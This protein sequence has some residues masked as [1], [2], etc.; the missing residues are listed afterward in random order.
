M[1][2]AT[3]KKGRDRCQNTPRPATVW[4]FPK[5]S[6]ASA[7]AMRRGATL[8]RG[9][10]RQ[11][12][13]HMTGT[14]PLPNV[15]GPP[16]LPPTSSIVPWQAPSLSCTTADRNERCT[17]TKTRGGSER[18]GCQH[19]WHGDRVARAT[20]L[21]LSWC[22]GFQQNISDLEWSL[23][24]CCCLPLFALAQSKDNYMRAGSHF[25]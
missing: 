17:N 4:P 20:K 5:E 1:Q 11:C 19:V 9:G 2:C 18:L 10:I 22:F 24:V 7:E 12:I 16:P 6:T 3:H 14:R 8:R 23:A 21:K 13:A 15:P 25:M